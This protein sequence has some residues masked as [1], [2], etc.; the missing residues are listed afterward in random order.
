MRA[1]VSSSTKALLQGCSCRRLESLREGGADGEEELLL[2]C[3]AGWLV[4]ANGGGM[5]RGERMEWSGNGMEVAPN[6]MKAQ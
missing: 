3:G 5:E 6:G 2:L 1:F 4:K